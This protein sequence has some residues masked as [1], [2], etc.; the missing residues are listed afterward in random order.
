MVNGSVT[1]I[2]NSDRYSNVITNFFYVKL[3]IWLL[4]ISTGRY[5]KLQGTSR[6]G[7]VVWDTSQT[8]NFLGIADRVNKLGYSGNRFK[9][10]SKK[11]YL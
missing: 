5:H 2:I 9:K 10:Y 1:Q 3:K 7:I 8:C 11:N 4:R 6:L